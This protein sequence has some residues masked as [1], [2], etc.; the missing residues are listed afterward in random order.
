VVGGS[1]TQASQCVAKGGKNHGKLRIMGYNIKEYAV[2]KDFR[3]DR[4]RWGDLAVGGEK[5]GKICRRRK[6]GSQASNS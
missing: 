3:Q 6:K 4:L 2:A 5:R 1:E